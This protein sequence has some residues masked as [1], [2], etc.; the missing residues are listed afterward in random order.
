MTF[1]SVVG[2]TGSGGQSKGSSGGT[3]R[4]RGRQ[5]GGLLRGASDFNAEC[6]IYR[7]FWGCLYRKLT[8]QSFQIDFIVK[9]R[10]LKNGLRIALN[11]L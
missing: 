4:G 2:A 7:Y 8:F 11:G 3:T 5:N 1:G 9:M 6:K 10:V